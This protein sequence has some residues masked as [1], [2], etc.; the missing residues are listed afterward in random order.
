MHARSRHK[1]T[2][3][4]IPLSISAVV[5]VNFA[6]ISCP[7][8]AY[9]FI[10]VGFFGTPRKKER[11]NSWEEDSELSNRRI[12]CYP[13]FF[14]YSCGASGRKILCSRWW[15]PRKRTGGRDG[16]FFLVFG[17]RATHDFASAWMKGGSRLFWRFRGRAEKY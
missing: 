3:P 7:A 17:A 6:A 15:L 1:S 4:A 8:P 14:F 16:F 12:V 13:F 9:I 11:K 10:D 5:A 2:Q